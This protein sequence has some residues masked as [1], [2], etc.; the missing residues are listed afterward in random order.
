MHRTP[1]SIRFGVALICLAV[2]GTVGATPISSGQG[3]ELSQLDLAFPGASPQPASQYGLAAINVSQLLSA[4]GLPGGGYLNVS[5]PQGWVVQNLPVDAAMVAAG[6]AGLSVLFDLGAAPGR[7]SSLAIAADVSPM[8]VLSFSASPSVSFNVGVVEM[9]AQGGINGNGGTR[10]GPTDHRIGGVN[11]TPAG[12][13]FSIWQPNHGS[14]E[15]AVNQCGPASLANSFQYLE[16]RYGRVASQ[17]HADIPGVNGVP[18]NSRVAQ[19]DLATGRAVGA[20]ITEAQFFNGKTK[21]IADNGLIHGLSVKS[22]GAAAGDQTLNG[23]FVDDQT[24][25]GLSLVDWLLRELQHGEDVELW[26]NW[27]GG[28]AHLVDLIGGGR[29]NGTPWFAW[30]HDFKQGDNTKGTAFSEGGI[31]FSYFN[32]ATGCWDN[33]VG[34]GLGVQQIQCARFRFAAS[35]SVPEPG[36][37]LLLLGGLMALRGV[38]RLRGGRPG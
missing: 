8:P 4:A 38:G 5:S 16:D 3:L 14:V 27:N 19:F 1:R 2:S 26:L 12:P 11:F 10:S 23:V 24:N 7:V 9:N 17:P 21:Y 32:A 37:W 29:T 34:D 28:G 36:S 15:Q 25:G 31:G 18:A 22:Y 20:G 6:Y 13:T 33:Y 30:V 35:E